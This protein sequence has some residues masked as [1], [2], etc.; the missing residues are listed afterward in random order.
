MYITPNV[1]IPK[2][3]VDAKECMKAKARA[4]AREG[5]LIS[6]VHHKNGN[7]WITSKLQTILFRQIVL[8]TDDSFFVQLFTCSL[9]L[10]PSFSM[11]DV[12]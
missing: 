9:K 5:T 12:I 7:A 11:H 10:S 2:L 1:L 6:E 8:V 3:H 4:A